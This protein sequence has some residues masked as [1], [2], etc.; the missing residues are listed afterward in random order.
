[1]VARRPLVDVGG[2]V[3][4]LPAG[5]RLD[6]PLATTT[7]PGLMPAADKAKL[8][9]VQAGATANDTDANLRNRATHTG[10]QTLATISDAGTA[11]SANVTNESVY[12]SFPGAP[13]ASVPLMAKA[14]GMFSAANTS[15]GSAD[16]RA[17]LEPGVADRLMA[18][19]DANGPGFPSFGY[20]LN[21][22]YASLT[23]NSRVQVALS[24]AGGGALAQAPRL[25][26]CGQYQGAWTPWVEYWNN[27]DLVK[28]ANPTDATP[29]AVLLN[30]AHGLGTQQ[31]QGSADANANTVTGF[32]NLSG[33][34][35]NRPDS[36]NAGWSLQVVGY[37]GNYT[38]QRASRPATSG[39]GSG[40]L[41]YIRWQ[42]NGS[43]TS[44]L[45]EWNASNFNPADYSTTGQMQAAI[46]AATTGTGLSAAGSSQTILASWFSSGALYM[47]FTG[48]SALTL[49]VPANSAQAI[50]VG[51]ELTVRRAANA[52]LTIVAASGVVVNP[53]AG[54]TLVMTQNMTATLKKVATNEWDLIGQTVAA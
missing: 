46:V 25:A 52:N 51:A 53:P 4:Q 37:S 6:L 29:G 31:P 12:T 24:Y 16:W 22:S 27:R 48:A 35:A 20:A 1:M 7:E 30:G 45:Q 33:T 39:A 28:Q 10:T 40:V 50:P 42:N 38:F 2:R 54:G 18:P 43:W 9:G 49:T 26:I 36:T 21:I 14:R 44:W 5:D 32:Y 15:A 19:T 11:A 3:K 34:A 17:N 13:D 23:S 8:N 47:R 41:S